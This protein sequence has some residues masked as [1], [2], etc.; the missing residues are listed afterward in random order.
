MT[1]KGK[2]KVHKLHFFFFF[3][4]KNVH[5]ECQILTSPLRVLLSRTVSALCCF[6]AGVKPT[7]AAA[8][9]ATWGCIVCAGLPGHA[10]CKRSPGELFCLFDPPPLSLSN[11]HAR[12]LLRGIRLEVQMSAS[13]NITALHPPLIFYLTCPSE[14]DANEHVLFIQ[15]DVVNLR[16]RWNEFAA[17]EFPTLTITVV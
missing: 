8:P 14:T 1:F 11:S 7:V 16:R 3:Y 6:W 12:R 15:T 5:S 2:Q 10:D 4:I 9:T 17:I 13:L